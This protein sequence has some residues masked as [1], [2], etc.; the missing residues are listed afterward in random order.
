MLWPVKKS[1]SSRRKGVLGSSATQAVGK[2]CQVQAGSSRRKGA[3]GSSTTRAVGK[4]CQVQTVLKQWEKSVGF[5]QCSSREKG[6]SVEFNQYSSTGKGVL[7]SSSARA[8]RR[9]ASRGR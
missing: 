7:G 2:K 6:V 4:E 3:S 1:D 5:K 9:E 8:E